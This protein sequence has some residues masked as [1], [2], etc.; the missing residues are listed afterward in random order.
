M[1]AGIKG[2]P[3]NKALIGVL[4]I[5]LMI[6]ISSAVVLSNWNSPA[7]DNINQITSNSSNDNNQSNINSTNATGKNKTSSSDKNHTSTNLID[8][9]S[10][11]GYDDI[12]WNSNYI[13]SWKTYSHGSKKVVIY[14]KWTFTD[15]KKV[16][17]QTITIREDPDNAGMAFVDIVPKM[18][19]ISDWETWTYM[20]G[21]KNAVKFYW[22]GF[23]ETGL[24]EGFWS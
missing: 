20:Q 18:S 8:S 15:A 10:S 13:N 24:L 1:N 4:I 7:S 2:K 12:Y 17:K 14:A 21:N 3:L 16:I 23:R 19:G 9:G 22:N 6:I 11:N 5:I